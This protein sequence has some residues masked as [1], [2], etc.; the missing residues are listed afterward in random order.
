MSVK[1]PEIELAWRRARMSGLDPGMEVREPVC[2]D[3][4]R[5]SRL[6]VAAGPVL[7]RLE[8]DLADSRFTVLLAD[9][10]AVIVDWRRA[11]RALTPLLERVKAV[12]GSRYLESVAGTNALA[13]SFELRQPIAV[14]GE[15]HFL[16]ALRAF[17]CYGAPI[18]HPVTRRLE[19]VLDITGP[20]DDASVLMGPF[21]NR[22]VRDVR[23]NLL[24]GV[25]RNERR[26]L[27]TFHEHAAGSP[28][29]VI[30][31]GAGM[32]LA[33]EH[34]SGVL[35][36]GTEATLRALAAEAPHSGSRTTDIVLGTGRAVAVRLRRVEDST[37]GV[38]FDFDVPALPSPPRRPAQAVRARPTSERSR[39]AP[40]PAPGRPV[41]VHGE[42]G[43]GRTTTARRLAAAAVGARGK[44]GVRVLSSID[45]ACPDPEKS[46]AGDWLRSARAALEESDALVV[47]DV[48]LV[49]ERS[50]IG[51]TQLLTSF[52]DSLVVLTSNPVGEL[53]GAH[54]SL[55]ARC[56]GRVELPGLH[57]RDDFAE[58][59]RA[60]LADIC[61][62][63]RRVAPNALSLLA[64][65]PWPGN[66]RELHD[67]LSQ[68]AAWMGSGD[69]T[70]RDLP[71][72]Y[73]GSPVRR[74]LSLL[75]QAEHDAIVTALAD[76]GGNKSR[77]AV[78]LGIGR[79]TLYERIRRLGIPG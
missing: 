79:N 24:D 72:M 50:A 43:T 18:L 78:R 61:G 54:L 69:I 56:S 19:G 40:R 63:G 22:A 47:D 35:D 28:H 27:D 2:A 17:A 11:R 33:N 14:T 51:L 59:V 5:R 37:D 38:T 55:A 8:Q 7:D 1:R 20:V 49:S 52:T 48:H 74:R 44:A 65:Q 66:L 45:E 41:L 30:V 71:A 76:C 16:E 34:A 67:V 31:L 9:R 26:V 58:V 42:P 57:R 12:P 4:E 60:M 13:T 46:S 32:L 21:V 36:A 15:E 10:H 3:V 64:A 53:A 73:R 39:P 25:R 68:A 77:A 6:A 29:P 70:V 62:P 23:R 75:E